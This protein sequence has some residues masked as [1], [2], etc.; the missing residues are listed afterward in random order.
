M[1]VRRAFSDFAVVGL[2]LS[3]R[4]AAAAVIPAGWDMKLTSVRTVRCGA[5]LGKDATEVQQVSRMARIAAEVY[6][7]AEENDAHLHPYVEAYAFAAR[8]AHAHR[9]AELG[10]VVRFTWWDR[11]LIRHPKGDP[12]HVVSNAIVPQ[13]IVAITARKTILGKVPRS[14]VKDHVM[15]RLKEWG[16]PPKWSDDEAD[17]FVIANEGRFRCGLTGLG[18]PAER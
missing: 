18:V 11:T 2:D 14:D 9:L 15:A 8:S 4:G 6:M 7:F 16:M 13:P 10:G 17:A 3:L 12:V 1:R 5:D